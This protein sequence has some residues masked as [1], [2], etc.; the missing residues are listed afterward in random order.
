[1]QHLG[2]LHGS[3]LVNR[4]W[5]MSVYT[6]LNACVDNNINYPISFSNIFILI[7]FLRMGWNEKEYAGTPFYIADKFIS[8]FNFAVTKTISNKTVIL[9]WIAIGK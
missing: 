2:L 8:F 5:G 6:N 3:V 9:E 4:Q 7:P 1:M